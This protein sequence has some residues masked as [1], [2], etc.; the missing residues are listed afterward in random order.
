MRFSLLA[1]DAGSRARRGRLAT[2]HGTV[3]TP[4]FMPVGTAATVKGLT[5]EHLE[6]SGAQM[7]LANAYHLHLRPGEALV[8]AHGGLHRF[9]GWDGPILTDSGG[10]QVFSLAASSRIEESG[11]TFRSHIDGSLVELTPERSMKVQND[12][13]ADLIMAFDECPANPC[14]IDVARAAAERTVRWAERCL[15][16]H[17]NP[18]QALLGIVQGGV[19]PE[20]R[21]WCAT[22]IVELGFPAYAVGGMAVGEAPEETRRNVSVTTALLPEDRPRYLMG[23]GKPDDILDAIGRGIDLFDCV[24]PTRCGRNALAFT[25]TGTLKMRNAEHRGSLLPLDAECQ[26]PTCRRYTRAYLRHLFVADEMLGP[27]LLSLHNVCFYQDL[28]RDAR[29]AI[30][31]GTF[32]PWSDA[33]RRR[34]APASEATSPEPNDPVR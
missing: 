10:F 12:L 28:V 13:G 19:H 6:E 30:E 17:G 26:C 15:A 27:T 21:E 7:I 23:M 32:G 34:L 14:T 5:V 25:R 22:R 20:V 1:A 33:F 4:A 31:R 2:P 29:D 8:K 9:M 18:A 11:V 24:L 3:D 16:A